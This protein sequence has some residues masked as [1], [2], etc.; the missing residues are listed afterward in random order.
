LLE[1]EGYSVIPVPGGQEALDHLRATEP[2]FLVIL[3]M[4]MP[5][6]PTRP[7]PCS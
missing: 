7:G 3:D 1:I 4:M 5:R 2:P 6:T